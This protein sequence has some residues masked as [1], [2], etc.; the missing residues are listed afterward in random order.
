MVQGGKFWWRHNRSIGAWA[1]DLV[2]EHHAILTPI[3]QKDTSQG[4]FQMRMR[5]QRGP[6]DW[7]HFQFLPLSIAINP[8]RMQEEPDFQGLDQV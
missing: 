8:Q 5:Q 7:P 3:G 1:Q 6:Q 4:L 2:F